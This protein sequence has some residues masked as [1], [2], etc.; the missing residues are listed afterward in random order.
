MSA[1]LGETTKTCRFSANELIRDSRVHNT[2]L[3]TGIG[4]GFGNIELSSDNSTAIE[5]HIFLGDY[6]FIEEDDYCPARYTHTLDRSVEFD[7]YKQE[8]SSNLEFQVESLHG[9][10]SQALSPRYPPRATL[11][12]PRLSVDP[13]P[14][15]MRELIAGV[16]YRGSRMAC[17][18]V[19]PVIGPS[20]T[21]I[22]I[23]G[24]HC[25]TQ[26]REKIKHDGPN[27]YANLNIPLR[28]KITSEMQFDEMSTHLTE[29]G[30]KNLTTELDLRACDQIP[31]E[32]GGFGDVYYGRLR[33]GDCIS[34]KCLRRFL[35]DNEEGR[36]QLKVRPTPLKDNS[37][38]LTDLL[39]RAVHEIYLWGK[40]HHPNIL[41]LL[42]FA[43]YRGQIALISPW[44]HY[45]TVMQFIGENQD[46]DRYCLVGYFFTL[47]AHIADRST[48]A[49]CSEITAGV[50][51]L[52]S[53]GI[54][55]FISKNHLPNSNLGDGYYLV[56]NKHEQAHGDIK[57]ANILVSGDFVLKINDFGTSILKDYTLAFSTTKTFAASMRWASP[58]RVIVDE[59]SE[60]E[61]SP[62]T[63]QADIYALG[64]EVMTGLT[65]YHGLS[66]CKVMFRIVSGKHPQRPLDAIPVGNQQA[67]SFWALLTAC[68]SFEA[69]ARPS[70]LEVQ[71]QIDS[72]ATREERNVH[73]DVPR[74]T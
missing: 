41:S 40:C 42:G 69:S 27:L 72:K 39:K 52:H 73:V 71:K 46:L 45:G 56:R 29:R 37:V 6:D 34:I 61:V 53:K 68:W 60:Y 24:L 19:Q 43:Q 65:P 22:D 62:P 58:E 14:P 44:M 12:V 47:Y 20:L 55:G 25:E 31:R 9:V 38:G 35:N 15:E 23:N 32:G 28:A 11:N 5:G 4:T 7:E 54:V 1:D 10:R 3:G 26:L 36:K 49:K 64:M 33:N 8:L 67:N 30:I 50:N 57:G 21:P 2:V 74:L 70:V 16:V 13:T 48:L 59:G 51:Y 66:V 18:T 63:T 17:P